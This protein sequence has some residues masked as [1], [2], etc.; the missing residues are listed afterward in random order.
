VRAYYHLRIYLQTRSTNDRQQVDHLMS[1]LDRGAAEAI[2]LA[3][4][5]AADAILIDE[6]DP[7]ADNQTGN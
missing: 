5:I 7:R 3:Y 1:V 6:A 4:E 2:V